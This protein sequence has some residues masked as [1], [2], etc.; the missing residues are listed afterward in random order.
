MWN[1]RRADEAEAFLIKGIGLNR[2]VDEIYFDLGFFHYNDGRYAQAIDP[3]ETAVALGSHWRNWH[4]LAHSYERAG[5]PAEALSIWLMM[6][7]RDPEFVVPRIQID[8]ILSGKK[9][10][11]LTN[12]DGLPAHSH[13][14]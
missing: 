5:N 12:R 14:D 6:E 1:Q 10:S 13:L 8:R 11:V 4:L 9:P 3:L 2:N 7:A